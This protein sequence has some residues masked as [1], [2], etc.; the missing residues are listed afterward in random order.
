MIGTGG[1]ISRR[2]GTARTQENAARMLNSRQQALVVNRQ[3]LGRKTIRGLNG[4]IHRRTQ[5]H[6][7][8]VANRFTSY[9]GCGKG[10]ELPAHFGRDLFAGGEEKARIVGARRRDAISAQLTPHL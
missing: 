8:M 10:F 6:S 4:S 3:V 9:L 7:A 5:Y 2:F 1:I